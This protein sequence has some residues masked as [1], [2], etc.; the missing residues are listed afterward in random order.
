MY[1][2]GLVACASI[3]ALIVFDGRMT[4]LHPNEHRGS[5]AAP[6]DDDV[7]DAS[8][9]LASADRVEDAGATTGRSRTD[10]PVDDRSSDGSLR[11][12]YPHYR[13]RGT[14][15][16]TVL[17]AVTREPLTDLPVAV[18]SERPQTHVFACGVSDEHGELT[19]EEL[20]EDVVIFETPRRAPHANTIAATWLADGQEKSFTLEVGRGGRIRGRVVDDLGQPLAGVEVGAHPSPGGETLR[21]DLEHSWSAP[22]GELAR[23]LRREFEA[24]TRTDADG[25][26]ELDAVR[27][28]PGAIWITDDGRMDPRREDPVAILFRCGQAMRRP[29]A[30]V[31]EGDTVELPDVVFE[32]GRTFAGVVVDDATG[33]PIA[34]ALVTAQ[35]VRYQRLSA[36]AFHR[37]WARRSLEPEAL[38]NRTDAGPFALAP[39]E[40]G[41]T[42]ADEEAITDVSGRFELATTRSDGSSLLVVAP[43]WRRAEPSQP[44]LPPGERRDGIEVRLHTEAQVFLEVVEVGGAPL[45]VKRPLE[46][47]ARLEVHATLRSGKQRGA[48]LYEAGGSCFGAVIFAPPEEVTHLVVRTAEHRGVTLLVPAP[49]RDRPTVRVELERRREFLLELDVKVADPSELDWLAGTGLA[50]GALKI[51]L[52][53]AQAATSVGEEA[54]MRLI[55]LTY[56]GAMADQ[57][58]TLR[59]PSG[60]DWHVIAVGPWG[61]ETLIHGPTELGTFTPG[62]EPHEVTLPPASTKWRER[63]ATAKARSRGDSPESRPGGRVTARF[64]DSGSGRPIREKSLEGPA[65]WL[66]HE[67]SR[68]IGWRRAAEEAELF[69]TSL[70]PGTWRVEFEFDGYRPA[71]TRTVEVESQTT[72]DLGTI[73]LEA[74]QERRVRLVDATHG[75]AEIGWTVAAFD[76]AGFGGRAAGD[77]PLAR[78]VTDGEGVAILRFDAPAS[79]VVRAEAPMGP[80]PFRATVPCEFELA[81][82][83]EG[84]IKQLAVPPRGEVELEVDLTA[85][86]PDLIDEHWSVVVLPVHPPDRVVAVAR[87]LGPNLSPGQSV[88]RFAVTHFPG[89]WLLRARSPLHLAE[90]ARFDVGADGSP[91]SPM[92]RVIARPR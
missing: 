53:E 78:G 41:F 35:G 84:E 8:A 66:D 67:F 88:L 90:D 65:C 18:W 6:R 64:V 31:A 80:A 61:E 74:R 40:P 87:P 19:I 48:R 16:L 15:E 11:P 82:W 26:Y 4:R 30:Q 79:L 22:Y 28:R 7:G 47:G 50:F 34:G 49:L 20:P 55:G 5:G 63:I 52:A 39:W 46:T 86:D 3:A 14:I 73:A 70:G 38:L 72:V 23:R 85:V 12:L 68:P 69:A 54:L 32:R 45:S 58:V 33:A 43:D 10:D 17:D 25:R 77:R 62:S 27:S 92:L 57:R 36:R 21:A 44:K 9:A 75:A 24:S 59:L 91:A 51:P 81:V 71:G 83:P 13:G 1:V 56:A 89:S 2:G 42:L 76:A 37:P 60:G 29:R